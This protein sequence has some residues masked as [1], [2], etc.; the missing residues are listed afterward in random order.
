MLE[1]P[2]HSS[3]ALPDD[4]EYLIGHN[5]DFDWAVIN[6]PN[7]KR[8]CTL[9]LARKAWPDLGSHTQ[10]ALMYFLYRSHARNTLKKAHSA[11]ADVL[12]CASILKMLIKHYAISSIEDLYSASEVARIPTHISFGKHKGAALDVLPKDY[13]RWLL[14]QPD[15]DPY[16]RSALQNI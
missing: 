11:D 16:L 5:I 4:V 6:K 14:G 8:I 3:F 2:S 13:I 1:C 9:A 10:S 15:I 7:L 12:I